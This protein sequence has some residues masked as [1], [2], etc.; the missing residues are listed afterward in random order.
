MKRYVLGFAFD[1]TRANVLLI[2]KRRPEWQAGRLNGIGGK[3]EPEDRNEHEAMQREFHEETG[4]NTKADA[5]HRFAVMESPLWHITC[6]TTLGVNIFRARAPAA[7][8]EAEQPV[9]ILVDALCSG[10]SKQPLSNI[11]WL[12]SLAL[13]AGEIHGRPGVARVLYASDRP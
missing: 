9:T 13:D 7:T 6:F 3:I 11:P 12:V 10:V 8:V 4:L 1:S 5:W 2:E